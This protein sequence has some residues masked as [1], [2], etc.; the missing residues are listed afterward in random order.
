MQI[1]RA[2]YVFKLL[3]ALGEDEIVQFVLDDSVSPEFRVQSI[4]K[5]TSARAADRDYKSGV[6][7]VEALFVA[8]YDQA[9]VLLESTE[10]Y[11][12]DHLPEHERQHTYPGVVVGILRAVNAV[13]VL[14]KYE[15]NMDF[16]EKVTPA[17]AR[18]LVRYAQ[19]LENQLGDRDQ[20]LT[21]Q[22][23]SA[24]DEF[25]KDQL[26]SDDDSRAR[27]ETLLS[28]LMNVSKFSQACLKFFGQLT[29]RVLSSLPLKKQ[30]ETMR[31]A[32]SDKVKAA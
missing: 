3:T 25:L 28:E 23:M 11:M 29:H 8:L 1:H 21:S 5:Y 18:M 7:I 24:I 27:A 10:K 17:V 22:F 32:L 2:P 26:T 31:W 13:H 12:R 4:I 6:T 30:I 20:W 16:R 9:H 14:R 15:K 19:S